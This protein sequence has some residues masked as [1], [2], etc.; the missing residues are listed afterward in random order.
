MKNR[1]KKF[2]PYLKCLLILMVPIPI[3]LWTVV[4][5]VGSVIMGIG[6]GFICPVM[7]TF[8]AVSMEGVSLRTKL[9]RCFTVTF[10]LISLGIQFCSLIDCY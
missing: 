4:G 3:A 1:T 2:D 7:D 6:Y 10:P 9:I 8:K 5:V